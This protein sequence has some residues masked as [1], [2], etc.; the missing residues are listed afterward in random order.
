MRVPLQVLVSLTQ[1]TKEFFFFFLRKQVY[2]IYVNIYVLETSETENTIN[3]SHNNG[4]EALHFFWKT[5]KY[6]L[7]FISDQFDILIHR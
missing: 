4:I 7:R 5:R 3:S 1:Y 6:G 2:K